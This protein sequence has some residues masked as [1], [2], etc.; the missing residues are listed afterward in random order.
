MWPPSTRRSGTKCHLLA[1]Q[2]T[3]VKQF[4]R[5]LPVLNGFQ[6]ADETA[7]EP[8]RRVPAAVACAA[9]RLIA[10]RRPLP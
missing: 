8:E 5:G 4:F 2:V 10:G 6:A 7:V 9:L 1:A 3:R